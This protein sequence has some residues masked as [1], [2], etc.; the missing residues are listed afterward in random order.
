MKERIM[1]FKLSASTKRVAPVY[2]DKITKQFL[3]RTRRLPLEIRHTNYVTSKPMKDAMR[4][5]IFTLFFCLI[6]LVSMAQP[7]NNSLPEGEAGVDYNV[8]NDKGRQGLWVRVYPTGKLYYRGQFTDGIPTGTFI[9]YYDTG[10]KMS[11]VNHLDGT[12]KMDVINFHKNG[13]KLSVGSYSEKMIDGKVEKIKQGEWEFYAESGTLKTKETYVDNLREGKSVEYFESGKVLMEN[14][15]LHD[16]KNGAWREYFENG[17][18]KGEGNYENDELNGPYKLYEA[19]GR[20]F[21]QGSY[22]KG[23]KD[24]LWIKFNKSGEIEL[25]IKYD[26]GVELA[27]RRENGEFTDYFAGG[28]PSATYNY[29][30]GKKNGP[31]TEWFDQGEWIREQMTEPLPGGGIQFKERLVGTQVKCEGDYVNDLL[32]GP[33]TWYNEKGRIMKIEHYLEGKLQSVETR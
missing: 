30:G 1:V 10:E 3:F 11:E 21:V 13:K 12:K 4:L 20:P 7:G 9:F 28:I 2:C 23:V 32:D 14:S 24:G 17:R 15:Y 5:T 31:F 33:V 19:N 16:Q 6:S 22:Y 27:T 26:K 18:L 25:N 29:E 8:T